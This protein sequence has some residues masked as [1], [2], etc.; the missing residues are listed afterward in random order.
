MITPARQH[1]NAVTVKSDIRKSPSW[2]E[3]GTEIVVELVDVVI[4][5][6]TDRYW[7]NWRNKRDAEKAHKKGCCIKRHFLI[8]SDEFEVDINDRVRQLMEQI[9]YEIDE[10][11]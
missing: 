11:S 8:Y 7:G 9:G 5:T 2:L 3:P 6:E 10:Q 1:F 4:N